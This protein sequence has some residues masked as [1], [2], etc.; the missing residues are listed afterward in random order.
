MGVKPWEVSDTF[1]ARV[2]ALIP[3]SERDS[4]RT[5]KRAQGAG[6]KRKP[7]RLVFEAIVYVLRTGCQWKALPK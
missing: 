6:R 1:W 4:T 5:Y 3:E 2:E 7:P